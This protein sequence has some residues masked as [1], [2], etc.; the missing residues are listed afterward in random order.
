M[1]SSSS[2]KLLTSTDG[3]KIYAKAVGDCSKPSIVFIHGF[4][5]SSLVWDD[6][7]TDKRLLETF[8]LVAYDMRGHGRTDKPLDLAAYSSSL[9]AD[10]FA[11]VCKAFSLSKPFLLGWSLGATVAADVCTHLGKDAISGIIYFAPLPYVGPIMNDVGSPTVLGF[12]PGLFTTEDMALSRKTQLQFFDSLFNSPET[13]PFSLKCQWLG[14]GVLQSPEARK[15][16][17]SR[18]QDPA[19]LFEAGANGLPLLI[20]NG[21]N[22]RQVI[23]D[24]VVQCMKPKF[25]NTTVEIVQGGGHALFVDNR[26][27][28]I[29]RVIKWTTGIMRT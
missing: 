2:E 22:D 20:M 26:E 3:H 21:S 23:G 12:L 15:L 14:C 28:F 11:A 9:Y 1:I 6:I 10:D 16:V 7:F 4:T 27:E 18:E 5:L 24:A 29:N 13:V 17:L 8:Y 19:K 25:V